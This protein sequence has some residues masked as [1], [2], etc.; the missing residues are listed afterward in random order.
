MSLVSGA[1]TLIAD[2][3]TTAL[4]V[5]VQA[6]ILGLIARLRRE[7]DMSC[8]L[9]SHDMNV[10]SQV[11]DRIIVMYSGEVVEAGPAAEL[12]SRPRHPYTSALVQ[13]RIDPRDQGQFKAIPRRLRDQPEGGCRFYGRCAVAEPACA[14]QPIELTRLGDAQV[15]C[16]RS[17]AIGD[18]L[19]DEVSATLEQAAAVPERVHP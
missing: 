1:S 11:C 8:L 3:P 7:R 17:A 13:C 10:L 5:T 6:R 9:I 12:L 14:A 4:D 19:A 2:E 18:R 15:R 16:R